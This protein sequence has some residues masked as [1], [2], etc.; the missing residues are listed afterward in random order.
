MRK[1]CNGVLI[2]FDSIAKRIEEEI[3]KGEF[4]A[5]T[6]SWSELEDVISASS[7]GVV[8]FNFLL[9]LFFLLLFSFAPHVGRKCHSYTFIVSFK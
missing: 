3:E 6:S 2:E 8:L 4:V 1:F 7:N 5:A 9:T